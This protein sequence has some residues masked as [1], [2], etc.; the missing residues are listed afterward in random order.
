VTPTAARTLGDL[1]GRLIVD[2]H[3]ELATM[4]RVVNRR[5]TKVYVDT[6]QTGPSRTIV[7]PYSVRATRGARVSTP[8]TWAE[9]EAGVD[10]GAFTI[11]TVVDRVA[12]SGD[13]MRPMLALRPEI[14][15]VMAKLPAIVGKR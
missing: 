10:P 4:E 9:L 6:G 15:E 2:R 12:R 8:L 5:G 3:P 7:A 11:R 13:P 14:S 1:F